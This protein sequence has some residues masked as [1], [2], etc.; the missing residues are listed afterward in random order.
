MA[1]SSPDALRTPSIAAR[2]K[3]SRSISL[4][5]LS[6]TLLIASSTELL[7]L[8]SPT[9]IPI[10]KTSEVI[11]IASKAFRSRSGLLIFCRLSILEDASTGIGALTSLLVL[12]F[13]GADSDFL[14]LPPITSRLVAG[15]FFLSLT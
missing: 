1:H 8:D 7:F 2:S 5:L 13:D 11:R 3:T 9:C 10:A 15:D 14:A 4:A 12:V 6:T